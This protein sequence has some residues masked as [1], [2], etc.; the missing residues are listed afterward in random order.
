MILISLILY[1]SEL[2]HLSYGTTSKKTEMARKD[3][4]AF[5]VT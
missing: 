4:S 5:P 1:A 2:A 3:C